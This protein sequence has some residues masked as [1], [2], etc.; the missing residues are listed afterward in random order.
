MTGQQYMK[1]RERIA[2]QAKVSVLL[3][4]D[5]RTVQRRE[6]GNIPVTREAERALRS[7]VTEEQARRQIDTADSKEARAA[8]ALVVEMLAS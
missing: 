8:L 3:G 6:A 4:V 5:I 2:S 1:L 7:L